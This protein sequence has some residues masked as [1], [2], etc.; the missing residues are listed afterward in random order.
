MTSYPTIPLLDDEHLSDLFG[1][2]SEGIRRYRIVYAVVVDG[3]SQR[4]AAEAAGVSERTV[5]NVLQLFRHG[6]SVERLRSRA[7]APRRISTQ[8]AKLFEPVLA[9]VLAEAP[10]AGGD[11]LWRQACAL[12]GQEAHG[13]SRRTAYRILAHL[14]AE[15]ERSTDQSAEIGE[16]RA[17]L[18]LLCEDPPL[19]LGAS[20]LALRLLGSDDEPLRRGL[21]L[22][23]V[24]TSA[25][26]RLR[27]AS[28][29]APSD[30]T[31]WPY[32]ICQGEY[33][34]G[35][36]RAELQ[37]ELALSP[38][39]YSRAKRQALAQIAA[40]L[41]D[42]LVALAAAPHQRVG[43]VLPRAADFVG[44]HEEQAFYSWRLQTD[45][46]AYIWGLPGCGK[47]AL[48]AELAAESRRYGQR[49]AWHE[50]ATAL[51]AQPAAI[52]RGLLSALATSEPTTDLPL[53]I[54]ELLTLL[55]AT[56]EAAPTLVV[57]DDAQRIDGEEGA[58]LFELL[59]SLVERGLLRLLLVN[60]NPPADQSWPA[61][62]GLAA[63]EAYA[64]VAD[65]VTPGAPWQ[66]LHTA[67]GGFPQPLQLVA[68]AARRASAADQ[69][70]DWR[71]TVQRWVTATIWQQLAGTDRQL[72]AAAHGLAH[73]LW[74]AQHQCIVDVLGIAPSVLAA[75]MRNGLLV[76]YEQQFLV[77]PLVEANAAAAFEADAELHEQCAS[78]ADGSECIALTP[79]ADPLPVRDVVQSYEGEPS[80][81]LALIDRLRI[82]LDQSVA[83]LVQ[84]ADQHAIHLANE[85]TLLQAALPM[86]LWKRP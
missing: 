70:E 45:R 81:G 55:E 8:R 69:S 16:L 62:R 24:L 53:D 4:Q 59:H 9:A 84:G 46:V 47:T 44:R 42:C 41:P 52:A 10:D 66:A 33:L 61:L 75:L 32:L 23:Q 73:H 28:D 78:F 76:P 26:E 72:L 3:V 6:G 58:D 56:L 43:Q 80:A 15:R 2:D 67:T 79:A 86:P 40:L 60:S 7:S 5:R 17:A 65:V 64:I 63:D 31:W 19:S 34:L 14:R 39:T 20:A 12:L 57:I 11:R 21:L 36:S 77:H 54:A 74:A 68:A 51:Q 48:A 13:L 29:V 49:V 82:A 1:D 25:I 50:C 85:L 30:R 22:R 38:S 71:S 27:P 18:T 37:T 35:Q 83:Y